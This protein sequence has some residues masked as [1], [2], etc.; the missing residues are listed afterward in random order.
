MSAATSAASKRDAAPLLN[1]LSDVEHGLDRT[2]RAVQRRIA[3]STYKGRPRNSSAR[4]NDPTQAYGGARA[5]HAPVGMPPRAG[6]APWEPSWHAQSP[7]ASKADHAGAGSRMRMRGGPRAILRTRTPSPSPNVGM[8]ALPSSEERARLPTSP[9][10]SI[11][12][13]ASPQ[14]RSSLANLKARLGSRGS[15]RG[16]AA[17]AAMSGAGA[18]ARLRRTASEP[19]R[20]QSRAHTAPR[21]TPAPRRAPEPRRERIHTDH[22]RDDSYAGAGAGGSNAQFDAALAAALASGNAFGPDGASAAPPQAAVCLHPC[23]LCGRK[24]NANALT[25]H[26]AVCGRVFKSKRSAFDSKMARLEGIAEKSKANV[27]DM[28]RAE[29]A[30]GGGGGG[31]RGS[32]RGVAASQGSRRG[33]AR[34]DERP[35]GKAVPKWK[36]Q[37]AQFRAAMMAARGDAPEAATFGGGGGLGGMAGMAAIGQD[38]G[39]VPCP[40][41]GRTFNE[42]AAER[43]IARCSQLGHGK[44]N[45]RG[46]LKA[47]AGR[48]AHNREA[49]RRR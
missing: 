42:Q 24:F 11:G 29:G 43:H 41:C 12:A 10:K 4:E 21:P 25:K 16:R 39:L 2:E 3:A 49:A 35:A 26:R 1:L 37:S 48:G 33:G 47:G 23:D 14:L 18:T 8:G 15:S 38:A 44:R 30:G 34:A 45:T 5:H 27:W 17:A 28:K 32:R 40:H 20:L 31:G 13:A 36:L 19:A 7:A 46:G 6:G 22:A 9:R